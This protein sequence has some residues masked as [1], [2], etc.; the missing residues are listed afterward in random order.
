MPRMVS[1]EKDI[2]RYHRLLGHMILVILML[3]AHNKKC[4]C[5]R[6]IGICV[7]RDS[8][9]FV[10]FTSLK[11]ASSDILLALNAE[12]RPRLQQRILQCP[13][14]PPRSSDSSIMSPHK[15]PNSVS[16]NDPPFSLFMHWAWAT[17]K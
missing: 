10:A 12:V 6:L 4:A 1:F 8:V 9:L 17:T 7:F 16:S 14:I 2:K 3:V 11:Q 5:V 13:L 15:D